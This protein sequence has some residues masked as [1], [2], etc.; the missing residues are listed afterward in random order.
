[1]NAALGEA[2]SEPTRRIST[3]AIAPHR[4]NR[5]GTPRSIASIAWSVNA[6]ELIVCDPETGAFA[7]HVYSNFSP[8]PLP[9][10]GI[11]GTTR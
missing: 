7:S 2:K 3:C 5:P 4:R 8:E 1:M 6:R 10:S 9:T 11:C